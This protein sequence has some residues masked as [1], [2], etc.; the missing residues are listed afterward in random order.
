MRVGW[1]R[2]DPAIR[3]RGGALL[4]LG[5]SCGRRALPP[6]ARSSGA[7]PSWGHP[8]QQPDGPAAGVHAT[9]LR[10]GSA[11]G[12]C[13]SPPR[14]RQPLLP[15]PE[16]RADSSSRATRRWCGL[17]DTGPCSGGSDG[18]RL[19]FANVLSSSWG[20]ADGT[21]R[22][23]M[24]QEWGNVG[25]L[26]SD[27][28]SEARSRQSHR[29][30]LLAMTSGETGLRG[31]AA[32]PL[33]AVQEQPSTAWCGGPCA[34]TRTYAADVSSPGHAQRRLVILRRGLTRRELR[35]ARSR[36]PTGV[37][38]AIHEARCGP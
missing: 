25:L 26:C 12:A 37:V 33:D 1:R 36:S 15:A 20:D 14:G 18:L 17:V 23:Q 27:G 16:R 13:L 22:A 5:G 2:G 30:R 31:P 38:S 35:R 7:A 24:Q 29:E 32:R 11:S 8:G 10:C 4:L 9:T 28:L 6:G 19:A 3:D 34:K 21:H